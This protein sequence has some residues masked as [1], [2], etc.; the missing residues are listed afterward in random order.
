MAFFAGGTFKASM[1]DGT[2]ESG[3][4]K[5]E[6][7][8]LVLVCGGTAV[9]VGEDGAFTYTS[10]GDPE[11]SYQFKMSPANMDTLLKAVK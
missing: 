1:E 7:G 3:S 4:F 11:K 8:K 5:A 6:N 10:A 2:T 9:T